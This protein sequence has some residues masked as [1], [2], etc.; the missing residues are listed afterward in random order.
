MSGREHHNQ[1]RIQDFG[2]GGG[3]FPPGGKGG[4]GWLHLYLETLKL[5]TD[6]VKKR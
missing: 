2:E 4:G 5:T 3:A 6:Y 1:W